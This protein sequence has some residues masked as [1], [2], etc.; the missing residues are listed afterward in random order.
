MPERR[1]RLLSAR[2]PRFRCKVRAIAFYPLGGNP[3]WVYVAND[4]GVLR[5]PYKSGDLTASA[6]P[7]RI[8]WR[9]PW[10]HIAFTPDG[11]KLLLS[12]G[13]GSNAAL[14]MSPVPLDKDGLGEWIKTK[15]LGAAWDTEERRAA[16]TAE[17][18][19]PLSSWSAG[20]KFTCSFPASRAL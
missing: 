15:P 7:E 17:P 1:P 16:M 12:V 19:L 11:K 8:I 6:P 14:D 13:S 4:D 10:V 9:V 18:S 2:P 5:F 20:S 3:K